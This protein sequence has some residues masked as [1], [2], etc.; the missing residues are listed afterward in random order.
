MR[1]D[2][3]QT[4]RVN[5]LQEALMVS[6]WLTESKKQDSR[7]DN[8]GAGRIDDVRKSVDGMGRSSDDENDNQIEIERLPVDGPCEDTHLPM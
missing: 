8:R 5:G 6:M 3:H 4:H 1:L 2:P 7:V